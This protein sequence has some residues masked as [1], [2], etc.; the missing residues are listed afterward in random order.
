MSVGGE[1]RLDSRIIAHGVAAERF[2]HVVD[3][4]IDVLLAVRE[5]FLERGAEVVWV[6]AVA[7]IVGVV[8]DAAGEDLLFEAVEATG[9]AL[10]VERAAEGGCDGLLSGKRQRLSRL[11]EL[12]SRERRVLTVGRCLGLR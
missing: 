9:D 8:F 4:A 1:V 11:L 2:A 6:G 3:D 10:E 5:E 7:G 12:E